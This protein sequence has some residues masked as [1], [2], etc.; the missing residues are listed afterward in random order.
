MDD[1]GLKDKTISELKRLCKKLA[2][3]SSGTKT[4]LVNRLIQ[5]QSENPEKN[6]D[7][8]SDS[9][10]EVKTETSEKKKEVKDVVQWEWKDDFDW[11]PYDEQTSKL[12]EDAYNNG[13]TS[14]K[15][16]H[17]YFG[18][19]GGYTI[20]LKKNLQIKNVT[21]F[22]RHIRRTIKDGNNDNDD[23]AKDKA[24]IDLGVS[25]DL[26]GAAAV[27][28]W[29][30]DNGWVSYDGVTSNLIEVAYKA[31]Q[32]KVFLNHGFFSSQGG[33]TVDLITMSQVKNI[34]G[35]IRRIRRHSLPTS[36]FALASV[37]GD[38]LEEAEDDD[39]E[40]GGSEVMSEEGEGDEDDEYGGDDSSEDLP[41]KSTAAPTTTVKPPPK[42]YTWEYEDE[43]GNWKAFSTMINRMVEGLASRNTK[44]FVISSDVFSGNP[45]SIDLVNYKLTENKTGKV[46]DVRRNP[47]LGG[48]A[49]E[50]SSKKSLK[51]SLSGGISSKPK[52]RKTDPTLLTRTNSDMHLKPEGQAIL[53]EIQNLT[54]WNEFIP[55]NDDKTC[56]ICIEEYDA[57]NRKFYQLPCKHHLCSS[58]AIKS[59]KNKFLLCSICKTCYGIRTGPMPSG[60]MRVEKHPPHSY[61]TLSGYENIGTIVIYFDFPDGIQDDNHPNPGMKYEGTDRVVYL[62]DNMEGNEVLKL[63]EI[64]WERKL[65]FRVGTSVTTGVENTVVWNGIHMKT[66]TYGGP[67]NF[68]YPDDSYFDRVKD[69]LKAVGV[70]LN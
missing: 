26:T 40:Y 44:S 30:G 38:D 15:L 28:Q 42:D 12:I 27:W 59:F 56:P 31:G 68:G 23:A 66:N 9:D 70:T 22:K 51:R 61:M 43:P 29:R 5:Y 35:Y 4:T 47:P 64:A 24:D 21:K 53:E 45:S 2:I 62:P 8:E 55:P 57:E 52:K 32:P 20:D 14:L 37:A 39:D 1:L 11:Q 49:S 41:F 6:L 34:T 65:L 60:T 25:S 58:C 13:D 48:G 10:E 63:F 18:A 67:T 33:Y 3:D 17:G 54:K 46:R 19:V 16:T 50:S 7:I 36:G 69:E